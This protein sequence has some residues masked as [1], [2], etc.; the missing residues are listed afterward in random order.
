M[1]DATRYH[2]TASR[3]VAAPAARVY[4]ILADYHNGHPH[5]LPANFRNLQVEQGGRGAGTVIRFD[6]RAFGKTQSF[7]HSIEEPEP[8]RVLV[9]RDVDGP[10]MTTFTVDRGA[11]AEET[12]VT[13]ATG[14]KSRSGMLGAIER[15]MSKAF[16]KRLYREELNKL[17]AFA[18]QST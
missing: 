14:L 8:G 11:T 1:E 4:G 5:I 18:Q 9:E 12:V 16:L 15:A 7:R 6:V 3:S 17:D 2:I 13:I 10:G